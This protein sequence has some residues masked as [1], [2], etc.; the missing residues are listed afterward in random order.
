MKSLPN[1]KRT[2][3]PLIFILM[4]MVSFGSALSAKTLKDDLDAAKK[5]KKTVFLVVTTNTIKA[6]AALKIAQ[7]AQNQLKESIVLTLNSD[8]IANKE[9][10]TKF[11]LGSAPLPIIMVIGSNGIAAGGLQ[12]K[13][14]TAAK[15]VQMAPSPKKAE[16][17]AYLNEKKSVFVIGY[18]KSFTDRDKVVEKCKAAVTQLK[19]NAAIVEV[20]M[21][22]PKEKALLDMIGADQKSKN[23]VTVVTNSKGTVTGNFNGITDSQK[24]VTAATTIP[25]Q[26]GCAPGACGSN[27]SCGK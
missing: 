17:L 24:L 4:L 27:K 2:T 19:G 22:D 25:K 5:A 7:Q 11:A 13:E 9:L 15:L 10:V 20:D 21:D 1:S 6:D 12:E 3:M 18:K 16:A 23:T 14:A 8:D 26:S